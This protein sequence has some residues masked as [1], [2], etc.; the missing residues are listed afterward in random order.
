[1]V[2]YTKLE[3]VARPVMM[4]E[5]ISTVDT[6]DITLEMR[7][8]DGPWITVEYSPSIRGG[9]YRW[10][11]GD[12]S[13]CIPHTM[14]VVLGGKDGSKAVLEYPSE[15]VT[16]DTLARAGYR[17]SPPTNLTIVQ[18]GG[19]VMVGWAPSPC[20]T[21]YDLTYSMVGGGKTVS[22]Q[23][24][25][26]SVVLY[27]GIDDCSE[28]EVKISGVTGDEY[29]DE[30]VAVFVTSPEVTAVE[31]LEVVIIPTQGRVSARWSG[32][33]CIDKY[34]VT[35]C[36][37]EEDCPETKELLLDNSLM[38]LQF[39]STIPL[40]Q[41]SPYSLH[42]KPHFQNM[43]LH[44]KEFPFQTLSPSIES[45]TSLI[46]SVEASVENDQM[47]IVRWSKVPCATKYVLYQKE[48]LAG[49]EWE[50]I[51]VTSDNYYQHLARHCREY[52]YGVMVTVDDEEGDIV[53]D[54]E[55][56]VTNIDTSTPYTTPSLVIVAG[57]NKAHLSWSHQQCIASY[58]VMVCSGG[59]ECYGEQVYPHNNN[60]T[61]TI[62]TLSP[63]TPYTLHIYPYTLGS[64]IAPDM[65]IFRTKD[66]P[67]TPP[68]NTTVTLDNLTNQV[69]I[70]WDKVECA[71][72]YN[73]HQHLLYSDTTTLW[74][75]DKLEDLSLS[76]A[77]PEPCATY[78]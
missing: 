22:R 45:L 15:V 13:P 9:Q 64:E 17:P 25:G 14:R 67:P 77:D 63:C 11:V 46:T 16:T 43:T 75:Y 69:V 44:E 57:D 61:I 33:P 1:M 68:H 49:G 41:C 31:M 71:T 34:T 42:I 4:V 37:G 2:D 27:E 54:D 58:R 23:V 56:V 29:S 19:E 3:I 8:D 59:D 60:I 7:T 48:T 47:V 62:P 28:Y 70:T 6:N 24:A 40:E 12:V 53:E 26:E 65:R 18:T 74:T 38:F 66:P 55:V 21:M 76:L 10:V 36:R 72:G 30:A 20:T 52:K 32:L 35:I 78:R 50:S 39:S 5:D 73:I 51:G